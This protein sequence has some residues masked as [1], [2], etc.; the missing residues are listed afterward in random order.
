MEIY[1]FENELKEAVLFF[2]NGQS[3]VTFGGVKQRVG[4]PALLKAG[5]IGEKGI[6]CLV[7]EGAGYSDTEV[8]AV[9]FDDLQREKD[10]ICVNPMLMEEA[11]GFFL[12]HHKMEKMASGYKSVIREKGTGSFRPDFM[13]DDACI[14]EI[15]IPSVGIAT[16]CGSHAKLSS[17]VKPFE[18]VVEG[19]KGFVGTQDQV[20]KII[21][22]IPLP[23]KGDG[24][25][26]FALNE[27]TKQDLNE[28]SMHGLNVEFWSAEIEVSQS[29]INLLSYQE[30][31]ELI[32]RE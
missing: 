1:R 22:L 30:I 19:I 17:M 32:L 6:A 21:F 11:V 13:L 4:S 27:K 26:Q 2:E 10:W 9:L 16:A 24:S 8:A 25:L 14:V 20:K 3:Y 7:S 18:R 15:R 28:I 12:K 31:T 29:G 5:S 23:Y